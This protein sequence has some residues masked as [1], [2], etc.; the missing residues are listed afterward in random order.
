MLNWE[1]L[2]IWFWNMYYLF[3][4]LTLCLSVFSAVKKKKLIFSVIVAFLTIFT[5]FISLINSIGRQEGI[6]EY[7]H[8]IDGLQSGEVWTLFSLASYSL[9]IV[10]WLFII[11]KVIR[12]ISKP[13]TD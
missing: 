9:I 3:L 12:N 2:P 4:L 8:F 11:V 7:E 5:P 1:T 13:I 10:W 6:N